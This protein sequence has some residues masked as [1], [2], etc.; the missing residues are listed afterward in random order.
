MSRRGIVHLILLLAACNYTVI[1]TVNTVYNILA[2]LVPNYVYIHLLIHV[3]ACNCTIDLVYFY[4]NYWERCQWACLRLLEAHIIIVGFLI[5]DLIQAYKSGDM[6]TA[7][8]EC[9]WHHTNSNC[10]NILSMSCLIII[11]VIDNSNN[12]N[13]CCCTSSHVLFKLSVPT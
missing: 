4:S 3:H 9:C 11:I 7:L 6:K 10:S 13:N 12:S 2:I 8:I 1:I 5:I